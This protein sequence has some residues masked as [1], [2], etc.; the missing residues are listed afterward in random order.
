MLKQ[1]SII[2]IT[3]SVLLI[4][5]LMSGFNLPP[6]AINTD[7]ILQVGQEDQPTPEGP[8]IQPVGT[9]TII[10]A[11]EQP[12]DPAAGDNQ[13]FTSPMFIILLI[14]VVVVILILVGFFM[15]RGSK[16]VEESPTSRDEPLGGDQG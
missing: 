5:G 2:F 7:G 3:L 10:P 11:E 12:A 9:A 8:S 6:A 14:V 1:K 16:N 15:W 13:L 4:T